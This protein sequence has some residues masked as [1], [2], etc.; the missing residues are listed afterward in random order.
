[1]KVSIS[2]QS[3]L[4]IHYEGRKYHGNYQGVRSNEKV[5]K[6]VTKDGNFIS[7]KPIEE[8]KALIKAR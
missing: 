8:L 7:S 1:M 2:D 4:D 3:F 5:L 6:Y